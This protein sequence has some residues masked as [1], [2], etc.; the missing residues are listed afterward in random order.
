MNCF[1][2]TDWKRWKASIFD[3]ASGTGRR[4]EKCIEFGFKVY[5]ERLNELFVG[6]VKTIQL[7]VF[8]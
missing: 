4:I 7:D 2:D 8:V 6:F 1:G 5:I 3:A